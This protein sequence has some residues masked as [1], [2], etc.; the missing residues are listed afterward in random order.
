MATTTS[1]SVPNPAIELFSNS[2]TQVEAEIDQ[3]GGRASPGQDRSS[4]L[5]DIGDRGDEN[6]A[7]LE[8]TLSVVESDPNDT[9]AETERLEDSP[10]RLRKNQ[11][12][13]LADAHSVYD[14]SA[15]PP[16][17]IDSVEEE[18]V[19]ETRQPSDA[20][21]SRTPSVEDDHGETTLVRPRKRK[22]S[23][24]EF[25]YLN[26]QK[27]GRE[28]TPGDPLRPEYLASSPES[29]P[30]PTNGSEKWNNSGESSQGE[31]R[32]LERD[33]H[34]VQETTKVKAKRGKREA[35]KPSGD[36]A[37]TQSPR[38]MSVDRSGEPLPDRGAPDT[39]P[40]DVEFEDSGEYAGSDN[41]N[42]DEETSTRKESAMHS[43]NAMERCFTS[44]REKLFDERLAKLDTELAMLAEPNVTHSELLGMNQVLEQRRDEKIQHENTL[45]KY[46]L[47]SL[48][49]KSKAEKA[50]VHGQYMQSVR[51]IR[52]WNLEQVNKEW[53]Q[54][55]KERLGREN[56]V[57]E[58]MYLFPARRSQQI[59]HQTAYNKEISLLSGIAKYRGFPAA[60]EICGAKPSE[61]QSDFEKMGIAVQQ[62]SALGARHPPSLRASLSASAVL[63]RSTTV[64]DEYFLEQNPWA[65]PQYRAHLHRQ[66]SAL[67]RTASPSAV[68]AA[69]KRPLDS[70]VG[71]TSTPTLA[72]APSGPY[73]EVHADGDLPEKDKTVN[74]QR[75]NVRP[76]HDAPLSTPSKQAPPANEKLTGPMQSQPARLQQNKVSPLPVSERPYASV[77]GRKAVQDINMR[78]Y[79]PRAPFK[80]DSASSASASKGPISPSNRFPII[81][82]EDI[83]RLPGRSPTPQQ[84]HQ[85]VQV[86]VNGGTDRF[87]AS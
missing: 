83:S 50:Q 73:R 26:D 8:Q 9:E 84:Y 37:D 61:I 33:L 16:L 85:P 23:N 41:I 11:N 87:G 76:S 7:E 6:I 21:S 28:A 40:D 44:L 20:A 77:G 25:H 24:V 66:A 53:Y 14:V 68:P 74:K 45:L 86:T 55:H 34:D 19:E 31:D 42:R 67:S 39:N 72:G 47:G 69:Q 2:T 29:S 10:Q 3:Q 59:T 49:N 56:N 18:L 35:R 46:K 81:K 71:L 30:E 5:S 63:Q 48:Q 65:N 54:I 60:P 12:L 51:D 80:A 79:M 13:V 27:S 82:A 38:V 17:P 36:E 58:Y 52:D 78:P 15:D 4:S 22:R 70:S 57:P 64:A 62:P 75:F 32:G 43:L 1:M